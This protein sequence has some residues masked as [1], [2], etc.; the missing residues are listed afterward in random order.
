[1]AMQKEI[2]KSLIRKPSTLLYPYERYE[3]MPGS[4][5]RVVIDMT[6]CI[7]CGLCI[8][9]C[10]AFAIEMVGKGVTCDMKWYADRCVFCGQCVEVCPRT[11]IVQ[12]TDY[13][14]SSDDKSSLVFEYR[15]VRQA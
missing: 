8:R 14:L 15:R 9:D 12:E 3:P 5:G 2:A 10:P 6:K 13:D 1:M 11:A 7:G 4:R